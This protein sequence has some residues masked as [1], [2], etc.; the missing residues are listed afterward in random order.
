MK[1]LML[2]PL[3]AV[4]MLAASPVKAEQ[5]KTL[6]PG[7]AFC[8]TRAAW[9]NLNDAIV[10]GDNRMIS[11]LENS[12]QCGVLTKGL[13]Y[14]ILDREWTGTANVRVWFGDTFVDIYT[15]NEATQ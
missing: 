2:L 8:I 14:T 10:A 3:F 5:E 6:E 7:Y 11:H 4:A 9:E 1:K 13:H 12:G 15:N